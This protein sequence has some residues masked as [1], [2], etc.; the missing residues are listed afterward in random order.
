LRV[1]RTAPEPHRRGRRR[2]RNRHGHCVEPLVDEAIW[3][4][5]GLQCPPLVNTAA[6]ALGRNDLR[7]FLKM[8]GHPP[9]D[10]EIPARHKPTLGA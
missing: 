1:S 4:A 10:L 5:D 9:R 2:P 7:K 8:S 3:A 6:I